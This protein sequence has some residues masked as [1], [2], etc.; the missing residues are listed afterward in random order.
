MNDEKDISDSL[1]DNEDLLNILSADIDEK[2]ELEK[3]MEE[4]KE[5][6]DNK[7]EELKEL[8]TALDNDSIVVNPGSGD[9]DTDLTRWFNGQDKLPSENLNNYMGNVSIKMDYGLTRQTLSNFDMMGELHRFINSS[10]ELLFDDSVTMTL[11]PDELED[12]TRL[13]FS[14]Y[15]ELA[16]LNQRTVMSIKDYKLKSNSNGEE[17]DKI[18]LLLSSIPSDKLKALLSEIS[19]K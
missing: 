6:I 8:A 3:V 17:I 19:A 9:I 2:T 15:K 11:A 5:E 18:S 16:A 14:M 13:A 12:R 7:M 1:L 4:D 10:F